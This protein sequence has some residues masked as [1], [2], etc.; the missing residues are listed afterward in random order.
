[1]QSET[2]VPRFRHRDQCPQFILQVFAV[3]GSVMVYQE[4][5]CLGNAL[6]AEVIRRQRVPLPTIQVKG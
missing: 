2:L 5:L 4:C 1:M 3:T 6:T